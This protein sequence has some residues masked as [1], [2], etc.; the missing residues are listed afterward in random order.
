MPAIVHRIDPIK[1]NPSKE[2]WKHS[3][4]NLITQP[5]V[6]FERLQLDKAYLAEAKRACKLFPLRTTDHYLQQIE[7]GNIHDPLLKQILPIGAEFETTKGYSSD[8]LNEAEFNPV[9]GLLHKYES[10]VLLTITQACAI[11][12]RYCFRREFNY[13]DNNP[14]KKHW[15]DIIN[16]I[17]QRP[18]IN[19]V[20]YSGGD[21][22]TANDNYLSE[23]T[24]EL[25]LL[26]Q[27]TRIRIHSRLPILIPERINKSLLE[28]LTTHKCLKPILVLHC[29]HPRELS[30][31]VCQALS[32]LK[33]AGITLL[34]QA[35]LLK[36]IN[37]NAKTLIDLSEALFNA[38]VQPYYVHL[39]DRVK[40]TAHFE[41]LESD[42]LKLMNAIRAKLPGFLVPKL[43]LEESGKLSKT[44]IR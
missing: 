20:I 43:A 23:L 17:K 13:S 3:L 25:A 15:P 11:H 4:A 39:L 40:G 31:D 22:L 24:A 26:P 35:V 37:N 38:G 30:K 29:N 6:L 5:E 2:R 9:P 28:W 44:E 10:R 19:E 1:Q 8:P 7:P 18:A 34:N 36:G 16:Y 41:V 33:Q 21:P 14:G 12:C 27:L 42:A 32:T